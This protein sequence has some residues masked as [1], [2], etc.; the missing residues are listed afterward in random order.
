ML[1][2]AIME[3]EETSGVSLS[4]LSSTM[5]TRPILTDAAPWVKN[6]TSVAIGNEYQTFEQMLT[7]MLIDDTETSTLE[8]Q[9][10]QAKE[11]LKHFPNG[12][13][14]RKYQD[15]SVG[16]NDAINP[17]W[18]FCEFDDPPSLLTSDGKG[19]G[20]GRVYDEMYNTTQQIAWFTFGVPQFNDP[21]EY[22]SSGA[23]S[24]LSR[25]MN[26]GGGSFSASLGTML[27]KAGQFAFKLPVLPLL[28]IKDMTDVVSNKK[29]NISKYCSLRNTQ[30]LYIKNV[31]TLMSQLSVQMGFSLNGEGGVASS[32]V[33]ASNGSYRGS[34]STAEQ[35]EEI[36]AP[37]IMEN[38]P[39][40]LS[41]LSKRSRRRRGLGPLNTDELFDNWAAEQTNEKR[42]AVQKFADGVALTSL[43]GHEYIGF[44][45]EKVEY[46]ESFTNN[47]GA[48]DVQ[49]SVN[50]MGSSVKEKKFLF[51]GLANRDDFVGSLAGAAKAT[52]DFT[53]GLVEGLT[54]GTGIFELT[55]GNGYYDLPEIHKDS[56]FSAPINLTIQLRARAGDPVSVFQSVYL[57]LCCLIAAACPRA[58]GKSMYTAPY[59]FRGYSKGL[60]SI[61][62]GGITAMTVRRGVGEYGWTRDML[63]KAVDVNLTLKNLDP[64]L[65]M[66][67][68][69]NT[70]EL[71]DALAGN[72]SMTEFLSTLSG[73]GVYEREV[74]V[75]ELSRRYATVLGMAK[76]KL[77]S[78]LYWGTK[79]GDNSFTRAT[80]AVVGFR[81]KVPI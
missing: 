37:A 16:G 44:R 13:K 33:A 38:G 50:N 31:N 75:E 19:G 60:F 52:G 46:S 27:G 65:F 40:L 55:S 45:I 2:Q 73:I 53:K 59:C 76:R 78:P 80:A 66:S 11:L 77:L 68:A 67:I 48:S 69:G 9:K 71:M 70:S 24:G 22:F 47:Y 81:S 18:Q 42:S 14:E 6:P 43:M 54:G 58:I 63:P 25:L 51:G 23:I 7:D 30:L 32:A 10:E 4:S 41:I 20:C 74:F 79:I 49:S 57:P 29:K 64:I 35:M 3:S 21:I 26:T 62:F 28:W 72:S 17:Y 8:Q 5:S 61:P 56:G 15:S 1:Y 39:D 34:T 12:I 36:G